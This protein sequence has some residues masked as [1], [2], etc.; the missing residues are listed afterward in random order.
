MLHTLNLILIH[1]YYILHY[2]YILYNW[3]VILIINNINYSNGIT[4]KS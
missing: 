4:F 3:Y 1:R 2:D